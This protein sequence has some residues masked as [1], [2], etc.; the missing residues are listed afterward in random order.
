M[1]VRVVMAELAGIDPLSAATLFHASLL[2]ALTAVLEA[3]DS[4]IV[5]FDHAEDKPHR[6]RREAIAA[7]ACAHAPLRVNAVA[8]ATA[9]PDEAKMTAAI[10]FLSANE[11]VTGQ[12]LIV[13]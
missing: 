13:G 3:G 7:L 12:L 5:R 8:P 2:P 6:W 1:P 11:G 9:E 4:L 10:A